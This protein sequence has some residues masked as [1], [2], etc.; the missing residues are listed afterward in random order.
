[1][2]ELEVN[3]VGGTLGHLQ[4]DLQHPQAPQGKG[5][6]K[7]VLNPWSAIFVE[8]SLV[9]S[10]SLY[11]NLN[12]WRSGRMKTTNYQKKEEDHFPRNPRLARH[13]QGKYTCIELSLFCYITK[14]RNTMMTNFHDF[15][16][17]Q[18]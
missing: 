7:V 13:C 5:N 2:L 4:S 6:P 18:T 16:K 12:A 10:P 8:G 9:A 11:M 1:M 15:L 3:L 17:I 14:C